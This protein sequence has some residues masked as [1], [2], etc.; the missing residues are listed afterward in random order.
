MG[1]P[2]SYRP[3]SLL[4]V[5][6][7]ILQKLTP[8]GVNSIIDP[9]LLQEQAGFRHGRSTVDQVTLLTQDVEDSFWGKKE[10]V[11]STQVFSAMLLDLRNC[12]TSQMLK[13]FAENGRV[14]LSEVEKFK[15][16]LFENDIFVMLIIT[17]YVGFV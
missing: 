12:I 15:C 14:A 13:V 7:K 5:P 9:F 8:A 4:C 1:N 11:E 16:S 2:H 10:G 17:G 6:F 3:I